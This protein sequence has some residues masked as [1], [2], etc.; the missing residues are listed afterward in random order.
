MVNAE[1]I[2]QKAIQANKDKINADIMGAIE[3]AANN[4]QFY[5]TLSPVDHFRIDP[6]SYMRYR[7][8]LELDPYKRMLEVAGFQVVYDYFT[9]DLG[10]VRDVIVKW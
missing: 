5:V 6:P 4:G 3:S 10:I 7:Q 1:E 8:A 9:D 2:R